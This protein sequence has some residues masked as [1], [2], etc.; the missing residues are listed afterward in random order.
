MY[1]RLRLPPWRYWSPT[2]SSTEHIVRLHPRR[3]Y[4][5]RL[6]Q[7]RQ[8]E[9]LVA[10]DIEVSDPNGR[11]I[12]NWII[13]LHTSASQR[14]TTVHAVWQRTRWAQLTKCNKLSHI[15]HCGRALCCW[16]VQLDDSICDRLTSY[17]PSSSSSFLP[18]HFNIP[19]CRVLCYI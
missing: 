2:H 9:C 15:M 7:V 3:N 8:Y 12:E 5:G 14:T 16:C 10:M 17:S 13:Q 1:R 18:R 19:I 6:S 4:N 11:R